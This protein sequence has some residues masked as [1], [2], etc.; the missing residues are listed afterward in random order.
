MGGVIPKGVSENASNGSNNSKEKNS[1]SGDS[2]S[3]LAGSNMAYLDS[4]AGHRNISG[5][6]AAGSLSMN[7]TGS[8][9]N[10]I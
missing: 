2:G 8:G 3:G 4:T 9:S 6:N 5:S 1:G 7:G 10:N